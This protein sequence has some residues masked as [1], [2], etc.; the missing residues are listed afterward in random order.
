[1]KNQES[2]PAKLSGEKASKLILKALPSH[3]TYLFF[4]K[5]GTSLVISMNDVTEVQVEALI[6]LLKRFKWGGR[7]DYCR[8]YSNFL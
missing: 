4:D 1:M 5:D 2:L 7:T 8:H 3:L 6:S